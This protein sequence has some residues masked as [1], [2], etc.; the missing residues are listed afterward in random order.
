MGSRVDGRL[1]QDET[2]RFD[3]PFVVFF[4]DF[5]IAF[6]RGPEGGPE[7]RRENRFERRRPRTS[8]HR[9]DSE[10]SQHFQRVDA[11]GKIGMSDA[12]YALQHTSYLRASIAAKRP[13]MIL[14]LHICDFS[15]PPHRWGREPTVW[16]ESVGWWI[17]PIF[18]E[19]SMPSV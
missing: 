19:I 4:H 17:L 16:P 11:S 10:T 8:D 9:R 2:I 15:P 7:Q 6:L 3:F 13:V 12:I 14:L 18:V 5:P 1:D